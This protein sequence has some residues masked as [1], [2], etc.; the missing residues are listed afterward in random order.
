MNTYTRNDWAKTIV[1]VSATNPHVRVHNDPSN[2]LGLVAWMSE[3]NTRAA[4]NPCASEFRL[5]GSTD[6]NP[7]GVQNYPTATLG[8]SAFFATLTE[9]GAADFGYDAIVS[10]LITGNCACALVEAV[11]R[12]EWGTW[13]GNP[14]AAVAF[15]L[16][17]Q[18]DY[19]TYGGVLIGC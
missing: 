1:L 11:A 13:S 8:L 5:P 14:E 3:E 7:Q 12:S 4:Y 15:M 10:A 17:V 16:N 18:K 6:F 19:A 9:P 2:I